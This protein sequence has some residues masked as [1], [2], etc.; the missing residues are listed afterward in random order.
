VAESFEAVHATLTKRGFEHYEVSNFARDGHTA[1]HNLG[2]WH[3]DDYLGLGLGAWGTVTTDGRRLR[4]RNTAVAERY[5]AGDGDWA[6][7]DLERAGPGSLVSEVE[8]IDAKTEL[9]ERLMLGLRLAEGVDVDE[10]ARASGAEAWPP[11]RRRAVEQL[12]ERG[13]LAQEGSRLR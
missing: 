12:I 6:T 4:Y 10:A 1:R 11:A 2:Y 9:A 8:V 5:L 7:A 13:R 3:G